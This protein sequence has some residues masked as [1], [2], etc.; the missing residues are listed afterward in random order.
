MFLRQEII[1]ELGFKLNSI[2]IVVNWWFDIID[3]EKTGCN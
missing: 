1:G 3:C 2:A